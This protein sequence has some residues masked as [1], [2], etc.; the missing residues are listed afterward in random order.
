MLH[1]KLDILRAELVARLQQKGEGELGQVDLDRLTEILAGKA[2]PPDRT[3]S[4]V[5]CP[6]CGF[7]NLES[8]NYCARCGALLVTEGESDETTM[9]FS[10]EEVAG[11][12]TT[13]S[14]SSGSKARRSSS[15]RAGAARASTFPLERPQ[16]TIGRSPDCDIFLDDVTVSRRHAVVAQADPARDRGSRQP[17]RN[18][19]QP[20]ADRDGPRS[21]TATRSRSA[22]TG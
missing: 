21:R 8:A 17:E 11:G 22:S 14:R 3:L 4:H 5:Y 20:L 18:L 10:A 19:P 9:T 1:G 2:A 12:A 7:Q 13:C 6:E 15:A 16:T